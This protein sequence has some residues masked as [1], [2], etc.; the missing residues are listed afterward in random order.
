MS[1]NYTQLSLSQRYQIEALFKTGSK[2]KEIADIIGVH[3]ST[4]CRE[5]YRNIPKRGRGGGVYVASNAQRKTD[6]RH[7]QKAKLVIFTQALKDQVVER[8]TYEKWSPEIIYAQA[9]LCGMPMVSHESIYQW[10]WQCKQLNIKKNRRYKKLYQLLR[11]GRRRRK[12]SNQ[13]DNRGLIPN[14]ISIEKRP[15]VVEKRNRPGDI[16][17]DLMMGKAHKSA[18]LI[19]TDRATLHTRMTKLHSKKSKEVADAII[20]CMK[21]NKH[22]VHTLTFD[23]DQAFAEHERVA[24]KIKASSYFT[25]P[26]TSQDKGTVENRIGI[27]RR[28][29]PKGT[30]LRKLTDDKIKHIEKMLN[31]RPIRKF[32]Y[33]TANQVLQKKIALIT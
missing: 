17:I 25:R 23:N 28:F 30:D 7:K 27:I 16:E 22:K 9:R 11:H 19:M 33:L 29:I 21:K 13:R 8:L 24:R 32:N 5:L 31:E 26:Y 1:K 10:I 2:Q 20:K 4:V 3:P 18:V 14:R 15:A 12:R 6:L